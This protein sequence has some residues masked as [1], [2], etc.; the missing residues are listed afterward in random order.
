MDVFNEF[1][2]KNTM[3]FDAFDKMV[4]AVYICDIDGN[5]VY[6]NKVAER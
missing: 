4:E 1:F 2:N 6:F 3:Y 5:L